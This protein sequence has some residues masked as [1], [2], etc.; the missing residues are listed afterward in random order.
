MEPYQST[1]PFGRRSLTLAHVATQIAASSRPPEK[2]VH[3]W[4]IYQA[5]C[6]ARP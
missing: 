1:T 6:R 3:K 5:I 4:K 2:V